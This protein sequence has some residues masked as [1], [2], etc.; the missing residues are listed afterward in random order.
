MT[1]DRIREIAR[2]AVQQPHWQERLRGGFM[3]DLVSD[4]AEGIHRALA[5][6][7][8]KPGPSPVHLQDPQDRKS[9][10]AMCDGSTGTLSLVTSETTCVAC[11]RAVIE[12]ARRGLR[13]ILVTD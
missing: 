10:Q 5:E 11:L 9:G 1:R 13:A 12:R 2:A 4:A 3:E 8:A 7:S 6:E